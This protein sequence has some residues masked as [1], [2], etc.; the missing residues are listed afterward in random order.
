MDVGRKLGGQSCD[1]KRTDATPGRTALTVRRRC[2][3]TLT[4]TP[5]CTHTTTVVVLVVVFTF[6]FVL[7]VVF[8]FVVVVVA[9]VIVVV[10]VVVAWQAVEFSIHK[11]NLLLAAYELQPVRPGH[12]GLSRVI[13]NRRVRV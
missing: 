10:V 7:V 1:V 4:Q 12:S 9:I 5:T 2:R 8:I 13:F 6:V 11:C 3:Q